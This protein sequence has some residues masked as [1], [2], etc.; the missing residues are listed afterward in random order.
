MGGFKKWR[1]FFKKCILTKFKHGYQPKV[2][3]SIIIVVNPIANPMV[4]TLLCS[5]ACDDGISS[6]TTTYSI[7]PAA[8]ASST[9]IA[10]RL[11]SRKN[12]VANAATGSTSPDSAPQVNAVRLLF[13]SLRRGMDIM[14]PSGMFCM[15]I[16]MESA[17]APVMVRLVSPFITPAKTTPTAIPSGML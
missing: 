17:K 3:S 10:P 7:A 6:S 5:P 8:K 11:L 13:F 4:P 14:A 1:L 12:M 16:P 2:E 15:A 9:G